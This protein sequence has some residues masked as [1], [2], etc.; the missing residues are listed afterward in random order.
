MYAILLLT[1]HLVAWRTET[2]LNKQK[3]VVLLF[4][5]HIYSWLTDNNY[6]TVHAEEA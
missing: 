1:F 2:A 5:A 4:V 6:C 3:F